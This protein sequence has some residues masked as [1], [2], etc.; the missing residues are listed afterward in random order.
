MFVSPFFLGPFFVVVW[1]GGS[2]FDLRGYF[3]FAGGYGGSAGFFGSGGVTSFVLGRKWGIAIGISVVFETS[4]RL[5]FRHLLVGSVSRGTPWCLLAIF[6]LYRRSLGY[7]VH[8]LLVAKSI[9]QG[10]I[11]GD[12]GMY[13]LAIELLALVCLFVRSGLMGSL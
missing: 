1:V 5:L 7:G 4:S 9:L 12:T 11:V 8:F 13:F 3:R 2:L 6:Y 10:N